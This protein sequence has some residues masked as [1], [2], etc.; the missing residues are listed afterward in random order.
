MHGQPK[1]SRLSDQVIHLGPQLA[2]ADP[3]FLK[4]DQNYKG[5]PHKWNAPRSILF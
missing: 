4:G 5:A 2:G 1:V 3:G